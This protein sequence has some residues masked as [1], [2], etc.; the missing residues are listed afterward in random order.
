MKKILLLVMLSLTMS[1][2]SATIFKGGNQSIS[3]NSNPEG[4]KVYIDGQLRG[5]TPLAVN[6]R[7]GLSG[8]EL[9]VQK[10]GYA[11][12]ITNMSKSYD[13]VALL[14]IFWDLSTTDFLTG[15]MME[16]SPNNYYI[17]LDKK[18]N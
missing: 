12:S 18:G 1:F 13:P 16:Y 4:A 3:I 11:T 2:G 7:K 15:S 10:E 5:V 8:K 9:R 14:N 6:L 17:Q